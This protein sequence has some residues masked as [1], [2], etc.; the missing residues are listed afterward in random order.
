MYC[1]LNKNNL[2]KTKIFKRIIM[3]KI[4][5]LLGILIPTIF[6]LKSCKSEETLVPKEEETYVFNLGSKVDAEHLGCGYEYYEECGDRLKKWAR[7]TVGTLSPQQL[8]E[9]GKK[10]HENQIPFPITEHERSGWAEE[11]IENMKPHMKNSKFPYT[12]YT[13]QSNQ[14]NAFTI[15]GGNI[16]VTTKLLEMVSNKD[17][18]AYIL[19]HELGHNENDHTKESAILMKFHEMKKNDGGV[20][21]LINSLFAALVSNSCGKSDELECDIASIYLLHKA[22]YN[23]ESALGGIDILRKVSA[24]KKGDWVESIMFSLFASHPWSDDRVRCVKGYVRGS[25]VLAK[26]EQKYQNQ[27]GRVITRKSPL[28]IRKYPLR[29]SETIFK[30]PKGATVSVICDCAEQEYRKKEDW[31]YIQYSNNENVYAGWVD[32]EYV[33]LDK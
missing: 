5:F 24:P 14:F 22:G 21:A 25:K 23:P 27:T 26:C 4:I 20:W 13:V 1:L 19:G 7:E 12:V 17:E 9:M 32:K 29:K 6:I 3:K 10:I 15:P 2:F 8:T 31:L 33:E 18:L 16:Y 28:G 11:I 30:I